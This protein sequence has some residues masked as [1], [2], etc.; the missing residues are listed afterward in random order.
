MWWDSSWSSA[1]QLQVNELSQGWDVEGRASSQ[2]LRPQEWILAVQ[3]FANLPSHDKGEGGG[4]EKVIR[5]GEPWMTKEWSVCGMESKKSSV[6]HTRMSTT[7]A[8]ARFPST[9]PLALPGSQR[10]NFGRTQLF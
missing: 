3:R 8:H 5:S 4:R 2:I 9:V 7:P 10:Q 6:S 1:E